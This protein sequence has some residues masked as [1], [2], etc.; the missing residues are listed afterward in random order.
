[1]KS[2]IE[3]VTDDIWKIRANSNIYFLD[4]EKK[5]II[6]TG[7]RGLRQQTKQFLLKVVSLDKVEIVIFT[8][9]HYDHIGNFDLFSDAKF[10]ASQ[11]AISDY[12]NNPEG[13]V[14]VKDIAEKFKKINLKPIHDEIQ[15]LKV[16]KTPGHTKGS[17]CLWYEKEKIL[18]SGDT[19]FGKKSHGRLDLPTS[20][21]GNMRESLMNLVKYNYK[22]LCPGH[23]Y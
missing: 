3:N 16:I 7:D 22:I 12:K 14:L 17:I 10:Y 19:L 18:F 9:L 21:P 4:F 23:D 2:I 1:M 15:G 5:I 8:H 13:T 6:D 20:V 11:D